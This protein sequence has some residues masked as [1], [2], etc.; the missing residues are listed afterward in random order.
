M[1]GTILAPGYYTQAYDVAS[2][3]QGFDLRVFM[4]SIPILNPA[5][6]PINS[7]FL[8]PPPPWSSHLLDHVAFL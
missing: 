3:F 8:Y 5:S 6:N 1:S 4:V 2:A 7:I